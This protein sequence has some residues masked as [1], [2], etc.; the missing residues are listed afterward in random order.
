MTPLPID[1]PV[2]PPLRQVFQMKTPRPASAPSSTTMLPSAAAPPVP[3]EPPMIRPPT[4]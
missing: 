2:P 1:Q 4:R 3:S